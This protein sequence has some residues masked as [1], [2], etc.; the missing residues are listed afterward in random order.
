MELELNTFVYLAMA[1]FLG[2]F[3][4]KIVKKLKLPNVTGYL[5]IGLICGPYCLGLFPE[6]VVGSFSVISQAALAF[7]AFSI[8]SEFRLDY[9]KKIG[10]A[11]VIIAFCEAFGGVLFV[12][13]ALLVTGHDFA[14]SLVLSAIAAATAPAATLMIVKQYRAKGPVTQ[15]L[16]PVVAIDDAAA[17]IAFGVA[18]SIVNATKPGEGASLVRSLLSPV[19]EICGALLF[20]A[21]LGILMTQ[22]TK[23]FTGRGNRLSVTFAMVF[24]C[25]GI[26]DLVGFSSLLACMAM[27]ALYV[28]TSSTKISNVVFELTDRMT[29]PIFMLFFFLSG[30]DLDLRI[31]PSVGVIGILYIVFRVFGKVLGAALGCRL[32]HAQPVVTKYLGFTLLPQAGVAIGLAATALTVVPE[33]GKKIRTVILCGTVIYELI[34]P[35]AT[36]LALSKAGEIETGTRGKEYEHKKV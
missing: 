1:L 28:N 27:S 5:I 32:S 36:K 29:P 2:L 7:I 22:L 33:Y 10:K 30:A 15:T 24:L 31:L 4:S 20:G 11:P 19:W 14:F 25:A 8:G 34:G 9:L 17:L 16:L 23:L 13:A 12:L 18:V 26:S 3:S 21:L 35:L 6:D